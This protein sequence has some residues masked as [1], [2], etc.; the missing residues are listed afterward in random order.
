MFLCRKFPTTAY[1][2]SG[3]IT[4]ETIKGLFL[5]EIEGDLR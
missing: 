1:K 5:E 4:H 3:E 2:M